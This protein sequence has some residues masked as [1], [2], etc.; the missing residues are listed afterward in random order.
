MDTLSHFVLSVL[1]GMA[2]G[3]HRKH[4]LTYVVLVSFLAVLIDVDHFLVPLGY[5]TYYRSMH[6]IFV[7]I[8]LPFLLFLLAAYV[9]RKSARYRLQT[10]FLLLT[11]MLTGHLIADML[12]SP[13]KIFYPVSSMDVSLPNVSFEATESFSSQVIG[14]RGIGMAAY[15]AIIMAGAIVHDTV[16]HRKKQGL[17]YAEALK[18]T[19]KD[20]I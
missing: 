19:M 17:S 18:H 10:F 6:N 5:E 3:L 8:L 7:A 9:E 15:A 11:I 20:F 12:E 14:P 13:V 2:V 16:Y 1:A 4:K